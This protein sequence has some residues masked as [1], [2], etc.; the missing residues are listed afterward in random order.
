MKDPQQNISK[1]NLATC[2]KDFI[3]CLGEF[4]PGVENWFNFQK[5]VNIIHHI[6]AMKDKK[7]KV[8]AIDPEKTFPKFDTF[9]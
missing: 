6:N 7:H 5:S 8:I 1:W 3:S 2:R 4:I 9:S